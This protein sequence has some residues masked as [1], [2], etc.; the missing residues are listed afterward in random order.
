MVMCGAHLVGPSVFPVYQMPPS[1][2][3]AKPLPVFP[4]LPRLTCRPF[5]TAPHHANLIGGGQMNTAGDK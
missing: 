5:L 1:Q 4:N 2:G 3:T